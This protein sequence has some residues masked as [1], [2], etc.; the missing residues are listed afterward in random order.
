[1][2]LFPI[3]FVPLKEHAF[4]RAALRHAR[5]GG[6]ALP[7]VVYLSGVA[8]VGK[9]AFVSAVAEQ[10]PPL[11]ATRI[12]ATDL[13]RLR[14]DRMADD[15][16]LAPLF[17]D[18]GEPLLLVCENVQRLKSHDTAQRHLVRLVDGV[19]ARRGM[20]LLTAS[21]PPGEIGGL[22][23]RLLDR[24]RCGVSARLDPPDSD[25]RRLLIDAFC[26]QRR[27]ATS[28]ETLPLLAD[29]LPPIPREL[30]AR[31]LQLESAAAVHAA[32]LTPDF[33]RTHVGD[34]GPEP[35]RPT[36]AAVTRAVAK[37]FGIPAATIRG[38]SRRVTICRARRTAMFLCRELTGASLTAIGRSFGGRS[39]TA[40][41]HACNVVENERSSNQPTESC[42]R[43]IREQLVH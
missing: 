41:K 10:Q 24:C 35:A 29:L 34:S 32:S 7:A 9:T 36:I 16:P 38:Q 37:A 43:R 19:L 18:D 3:P 30:F 23:P 21:R 28:T 17:Q 25:G 15:G 1:M 33:V 4:P 39:H 8:G 13:L 26:S 31:L 22:S 11:P 40:V 42:L 14:L 27:L 6:D 2:S 20:V 12:E 5:R